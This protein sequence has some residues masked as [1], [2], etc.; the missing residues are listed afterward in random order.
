MI[1]LIDKS[2]KTVDELHTKGIQEKT[3]QMIIDHLKENPN[4]WFTGDEIAEKT[5]LTGVTVRRYMTHLT[6]IGKVIGGMNYETGERPCM[7]YKISM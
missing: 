2:R 6:E 3:M 4:K 5:K 7:L 1:N